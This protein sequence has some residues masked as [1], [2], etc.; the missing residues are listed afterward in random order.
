MFVISILL[1]ILSYYFIEQPFRKTSK[2]KSQLKPAAFGLA[3]AACAAILAYPASSIWANNGFEWRL[4]KQR[5]NKTLV[6]E[7]IENTNAKQSAM[8]AGEKFRKIVG[9][10]STS[11]DCLLYTSPSPRDRG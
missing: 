9:Y 11:K 8:V 1:S 4:K 3:C 6:H 10:G 7:L 5:P 2:D